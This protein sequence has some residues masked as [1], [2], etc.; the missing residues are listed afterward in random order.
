[1]VEGVEHRR[2]ERNSGLDRED[3]P[4]GGGEDAALMLPEPGAPA[5]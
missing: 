3:S 1:M 5:R 2:S 4:S